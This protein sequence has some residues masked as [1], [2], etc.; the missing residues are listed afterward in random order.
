MLN[1]I[2]VANKA[3]AKLNIADSRQLDEIAVKVIKQDTPDFL[4]PIKVLDIDDKIEIRYELGSR[5]RLSYLPDIMTKQEFVILLENLLRP[6]KNCNDWFLDYHNFYLD[7]AYITVG[8]SYSDVRYVYIPDL[9]YRNEENEILDFFRNFILNTNLSDEPMYVMNLYRCLNERDASVVSILDHIANDTAVTPVT[10]SV[11]VEKPVPIPP[12]SLQAS[13]V[14]TVDVKQESVKES[15]QKK[16]VLENSEFGKEDARGGL[17]DNLFGEEEAEGTRKSGGI[18][19][20]KKEKKAPKAE[21]KEKVKKTGGIFGGILGGRKITEEKTEVSVEQLMSQASGL[22][23]EK[24]HTSA[25]PMMAAPYY[26]DTETAIAGEEEPADME[27]ML[28]LM[29]ESDGG[30][31]FPKYI[32]VDMSRGYATIGRMDKAGNKQ[33]DYNFD[34]AFSFISRRHLRVEKRGAQY[35]II[36]LA[37]DK[38]GTLLNG[39][40]L[41][42]NMAYPIKA[43]DKI[44]F[45]KKHRITYRVG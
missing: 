38:N 31:A 8:K 2:V 7:K 19:S 9:N 43:G 30:Y 18:F 27:N 36:D 28:V 23:A 26:D 4:L 3:Y 44:M 20:S 12:V 16:A 42:A 25:V 40:V 10:T 17:I 22:A 35:V 1:D 24:N 29:L 5:M 45:S 13:A 39:E 37:A 14:N 34:S 41:T 21:P 15:V 32:E 11:S 6:F 33:S